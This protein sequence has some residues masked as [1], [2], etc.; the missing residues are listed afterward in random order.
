MK[1]RI[2][3]T[4][5]LALLASC[6]HEKKEFNPLQV[7]V[8]SPSGAAM[9]ESPENG[10]R[11]LCVVPYKTEITAVD[12]K[13]TSGE[14]KNTEDYWYQ[15]TFMQHKGWVLQEQVATREEFA[16]QQFQQAVCSFI[17]DPFMLKIDMRVG[18]KKGSITSIFVSKFGDP[19]KTV[20]EKIA[21][22]KIDNLD[23]VKLYF[24]G[25]EVRIIRN[26]ME[27]RELLQQ[28]IVTGDKACMKFKI[29]FSKKKEDIIA[30][31]GEA[32]VNS[33]DRLIYSCGKFPGESVEFRFGKKGLQGI[34]LH[35]Y[36]D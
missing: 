5:C 8:A 10:S 1:K 24:P 36:V 28:V 19:V 7:I 22:S 33:E 20:T 4:I 32:D 9:H 15:V 26:N 18:D 2:L 14:E 16:R 17:E 11:E 23:L 29:T 27:R 30:V 21:R 25:M 3:F 13:A 12:E 35:C 31:F 6:T 34:T